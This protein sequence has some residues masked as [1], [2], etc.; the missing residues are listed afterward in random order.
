MG[1]DNGRTIEGPVKENRGFPV[2]R[3]TIPLTKK[4]DSLTAYDENKIIMGARDEL[5]ILDCS[6]KSITPLSICIKAVLNV[7]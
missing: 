7:S 5:Q 2:C 3:M 4:V 1:C 6:Q